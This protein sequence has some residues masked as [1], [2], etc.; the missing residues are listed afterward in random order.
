MSLGISW[1]FNSPMDISIPMRHGI[2]NPRAFSIDYPV[3]EPFRAGTFVGDV[4]C[5]SSCNVIGMR[6]NPHGNGTHTECVGHLG[7]D[8]QGKAGHGP[9]SCLKVN[10]AMT[11]FWFPVQVVTVNPLQK[12]VLHA[13][14]WITRKLL[15]DVVRTSHDG[16][17]E[18]LVVRTLPN[19]DLKMT[20]DYSETSPVAFEPEAMDFLASLGILHLLTDLPSVDPEHDQGSLLA[21]KAFWGVDSGVRTSAT[22]TELI[23]VPSSI[24][25][26]MYI[27]NLML[28]NIELDAV[29]SRPIL[30]S[31]QARD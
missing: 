23:Y 28:P 15:E 6:I 18:G 20:M 10:K 11:K 9:D 7:Y 21:H 24:T 13:Q 17:V 4:S 5:G 3:F 30:Y 26:G 29:P 8:D 22:I 16:Q 19:H 1:D 12:D 14:R 27:L 31:R 2:Q 25:D